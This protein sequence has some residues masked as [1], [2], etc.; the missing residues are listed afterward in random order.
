MIAFEKDE[1][2]MISLI[3]AVLN[4]GRKKFSMQDFNLQSEIK[5][6]DLIID[7]DHLEYVFKRKSESIMKM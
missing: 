6:F 1:E 3:L 2:E 4:T 5:Y 7:L